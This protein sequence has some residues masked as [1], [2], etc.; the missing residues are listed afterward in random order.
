MGRAE[1][2]RALRALKQGKVTPTEP[3]QITMEQ[4][5]EKRKTEARL[6]QLT[7]PEPGFVPGHFRGNPNGYTMF[8]VD[9]AHRYAFAHKQ[10]LWCPEHWAPCPVEGRDGRAAS[11]ALL[12]YAMDT[13]MPRNLVSV[14]GRL[15]WLEQQTTPLCC[16]IKSEFVDL[17]WS[18]VPVL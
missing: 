8:M 1:N 13:K 17:V 10:G 12:K 6:L 5:D 16:Q 11:V 7:E 4:M 3:G 15:R 9:P 18:G 2:R 14:Q